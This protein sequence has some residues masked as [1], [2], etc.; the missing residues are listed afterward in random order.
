M[1]FNSLFRRYF[2]E[3]KD[4]SQDK[5]DDEFA[6]IATINPVI[7]ATRSLPARRS[8]SNSDSVYNWM[9][10][11]KRS[12]DSYG[13]KFPLQGRDETMR[14]LFNGNGAREG[15]KGCAKDLK[16]HAENYT[17][18]DELL[19][20]IKYRMYAINVTFGNGT[21][22]S[23]EDTSIGQISVVLQI[24]YEN[25]ISGTLGYGEFLEKCSSGHNNPVREIV[26]AV[27]GLSCLV[28]EYSMCRSLLE[29]FKVS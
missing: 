24:L 28:P 27:D 2:K 4:D 21:P 22:A 20:R 23:E 9:K 5:E 26:R 17:N 18:D 16:T 7:V 3:L 14:V 12:M 8:T 6:E 1:E 29:Q 10:I 19:D 11:L 13:A 15:L 25:F